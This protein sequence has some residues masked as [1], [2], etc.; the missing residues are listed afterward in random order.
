MI[1]IICQTVGFIGTIVMLGLGIY[2]RYKSKIIECEEIPCAMI[3]GSNLCSI[4]TCPILINIQYYQNKTAMVSVYTDNN[5]STGCNWSHQQI[6]VIG[7]VLIVIGSI[8]MFGYAFICFVNLLGRYVVYR[9]E[10]YTTQSRTVALPIYRVKVH[11]APSIEN[12]DDFIEEV[13]PD[14]ENQDICSICIE[15]VCKGGPAICIKHCKHKFHKECIV[16]WFSTKKVC[17]ICRISV[18]KQRQ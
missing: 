6:R 10:I 14:I 18:D 13:K 15:P 5:C 4:K 1:E 3:V 12:F 11:P 2:F 7:D 17:P 16:V 9:Q 8:I